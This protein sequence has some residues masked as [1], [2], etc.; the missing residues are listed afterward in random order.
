[1]ETGKSSGRYKNV[2]CFFVDFYKLIDFCRH[3]YVKTLYNIH[4]SL[5]KMRLRNSLC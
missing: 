4:I 1:M 2:C 3:E 5:N